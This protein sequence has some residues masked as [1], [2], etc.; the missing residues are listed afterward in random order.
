MRVYSLF[1]M[2]PIAV[3]L[4]SCFSLLIA[5]RSCSSTSFLIRWIRHFQTNVI[6]LCSCVFLFSVHGSCV[7]VGM[8]HMCLLHGSWVSLCADSWVR[9]SIIQLYVFLPF[10]TRG[11]EFWRQKKIHS[12]VYWV[13]VIFCFF[14]TFCELGDVRRGW[15]EY[16][17]SFFT[18]SPCLCIDVPPFEIWLHA[19]CVSS[20]WF[21]S[22]QNRV[23]K[24][25]FDWLLCLLCL[26]WLLVVSSCICALWNHGDC[27][28]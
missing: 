8:F 20:L 24:G 19:R 21:S 16:C 18:V 14:S 1:C 15:L 9:D 23:F 6:F 17:M 12:L 3:S 28:M 13:F 27:D 26:V 25:I 10:G 22:G 11:Q 2:S 7:Y 5:L 4:I